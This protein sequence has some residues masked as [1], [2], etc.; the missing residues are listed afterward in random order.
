MF[1]SNELAPTISCLTLFPALFEGF[2][3]EGI[4]A[5]AIAQKKVN[6]QTVSFRD[7]S[8]DVRKNVDDSPVGGGDGM[9]LLPEVCEAALLSVLRPKSFVVELSPRGKV[10]NA[11]AAKRFSEILLNAEHLV[12][13]CG[14]YAGFDARFSEKYVHE[15]WS[16][17][18]FVLS[19]GE[20]P[21]IFMMDALLRFV[22][23]VLGNSLSSACDSH[24]DGLLEA[25]SYTKPLEWHGKEVPKVLT[26]GNH[27]KIAQYRRLEQ[28]K[29]TAKQRP[30]LVLQAWDKLSRQEK[31]V[32][33]RVFKHRA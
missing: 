4:I 12:F 7:F 10:F 26:S 25:P 27:E 19:G 9:V 32:A 23:G 18:D 30:D 29:E 17:G 5:R 33:E 28:I 15:S 11:Q 13:L 20:F 14:R 2:V 3:K 8:T 24:S 6:F 22:P 1:D 16:V 31:S 21:A